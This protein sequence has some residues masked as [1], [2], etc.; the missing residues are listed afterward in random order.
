MDPIIARNVLLQAVRNF[1]NGRDYLEVDTPTLVPCPGMEVHLDYFS[2]PW[3]DHHNNRHPLYLRSSPELHMKQLLTRG[4]KRI[5]QLAKSFRNNGEFSDWH[6]PEFTLLEWY[7]QNISYEHFMDMTH[8]F[9]RVSSQD[10]NKKNRCQNL[11]I[12][13]A[14]VKISVKEAFKTFAKIDIIDNDPELAARARTLGYHSVHSQDDFES[15]YFKIWL[16]IIEPKLKELEYAVIYDFLP[17]QA[18]LAKIEENVA[19]RFEF[20]VKG[21]E[22]SNAFSELIDYQENI[23]RCE[24]IYQI[25]TNQNKQ[26]TPIDQYFTE[27]L[28]TGLQPSC[29]NALGI[30]RWLALLA[31]ENSIRP[32]LIFSEQIYC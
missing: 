3:L 25:R 32:F 1:F 27:S 21:I 6:N 20:Y 24:K 2:S 23:R 9:L 5:F 31:G 28:A 12:T 15:A 7:E 26:D 17:S 4:Y 29:G 13:S 18:A 22:L 8:D 16:D 14:P 19:K 10:F 11:V 30:D